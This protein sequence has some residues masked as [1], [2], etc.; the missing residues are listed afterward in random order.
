MLASQVMRNVPLVLLHLIDY[1][2]QINEQ[3][4][5]YYLAPLSPHLSTTFLVLRCWRAVRPIR[6]PWQPG[7]Y[8][9]SGSSTQ[10]PSYGTVWKRR[11]WA[12]F[13]WRPRSRKPLGASGTSSTCSITS[14]RSADRSKYPATTR[15]PSCSHPT[16]HPFDEP[17]WTNTLY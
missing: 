5:T 7:R 1:S 12:A 10:S 11:R 3:L 13:A 14:N 6:W 9:S 2:I 8:C 17:P 15:N 16:R 4:I